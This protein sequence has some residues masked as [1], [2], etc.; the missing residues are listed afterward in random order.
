MQSPPSQP[1]WV[2]IQRELI[3]DLTPIDHGPV[4][5]DVYDAFEHAL[6]QEMDQVIQMMLEIGEENKLTASD[7]RLILSLRGFN[8]CSG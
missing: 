7:I 4:S 3:D 6:N 1:K 8:F 5:N 2:T